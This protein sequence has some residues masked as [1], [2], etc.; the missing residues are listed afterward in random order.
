MLASNND[1]RIGC[2]WSMLVLRTP[3]L[4]DF[5]LSARHGTTVYTGDTIGKVVGVDVPGAG[6]ACL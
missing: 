6:Q 5:A 3:E 4:S 1:R 2:S